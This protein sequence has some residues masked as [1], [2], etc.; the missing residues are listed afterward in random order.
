MKEYFLSLVNYNAWANSRM[1][2]F[3]SAAGEES[4][5]L[6]QK[7]SFPTIRATA[8]HIWDAEGIWVNR[9]NG[10]SITGWPSKDFSGSTLEGAKQWLDTSKAFAELV[11]KKSE[12]DFHEMIHYNNTKGIPFQNSFQ[13]IIAHVMNHSTFHRGQ[14]V[15]MLRGADFTELKSTDLIAFYRD[16]Q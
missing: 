4:S 5:L 12:S 7:S 9:L 14:L 3:I 8:F 2:D 15:T 6:V 1:C 13:Q 11:S 10:K 16:S